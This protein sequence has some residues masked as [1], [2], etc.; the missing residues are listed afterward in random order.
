MK[1]E[2]ND[3]KNLSARILEFTRRDKPMLSLSDPMIELSASS[4]LLIFEAYLEALVRLR[5]LTTEMHRL[6]SELQ[7]N[8]IH[9]TV[10]GGTPDDYQKSIRAI[11]Y[12][13]NELD[14]L[15]RGFAAMTP[16]RRQA[17]G[18]LGG[19]AS[20]AKGTGHHWTRDEAKIAGKK[21]GEGLRRR[22]PKKGGA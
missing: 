16:E 15:P 7:S 6:I 17:I 10:I 2:S 20:Q 4:I 9:V 14:R 21:G 13:I 11:D 18:R 19:K 22:R 1:D 12:S 3:E 5:S 8:G